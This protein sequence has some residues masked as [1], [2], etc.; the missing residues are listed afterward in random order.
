MVCL[1][2]HPTDCCLSYKNIHHLA[3]KPSPADIF[4]LVRWHCDREAEATIPP[5]LY[6]TM[7]NPMKRLLFLGLCMAIPFCSIAEAISLASI[8]TFDTDT[9]GWEIAGRGADPTFDNGLSFNGQPGFLTHFSDNSGPNSRWLML[10]DESDWTGDYLSAGVGSISLWMDG[11][12]GNADPIVWLG[13]EGPGGWFFTPGQVLPISDDWKRY[14]F[15]VTPD[16]L[17]HSTA[18]G[19]TGVAADTLA[20]VTQFEIFAGPGPV[21]YRGNGNLLEGGRSTSV[22]NIDNIAAQPVPEPTSVVLLGLSLS[23]GAV[24]R[25]RK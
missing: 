14:E 22:I 13:F 20:A 25:K 9:E 8:D 12:S 11:V 23:A 4:S 5:R 21:N 16:S 19:G 10:S 24:L 15:D 1:T 17:I 3:I 7:E 6:D 2:A 18:S